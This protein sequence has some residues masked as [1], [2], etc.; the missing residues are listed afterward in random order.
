MANQE[1]VLALAQVIARA[2]LQFTF[3][4][5][6]LRLFYEIQL[7]VVEFVSNIYMYMMLYNCIYF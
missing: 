1:N 4:V 6:M 2:E 7:L 3:C 5:D